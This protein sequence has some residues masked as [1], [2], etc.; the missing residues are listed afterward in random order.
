MPAFNIQTAGWGVRGG[1]PSAHLSEVLTQSTDSSS[2]R[3]V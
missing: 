2:A 1:A 3:L